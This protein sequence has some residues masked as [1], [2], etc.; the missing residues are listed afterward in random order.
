MLDKNNPESK[1]REYVESSFNIHVFNENI[2][3]RNIVFQVVKMQ[4]SC[5]VF[6]NDKED[7]QLLNLTLSLMSRFEKEPISTNLIGLSADNT[8]NNIAT[9]LTKK[10]KKAVYVSYNLEDSRTLTPAV[11]KRLY[12]EIRTNP[13]NF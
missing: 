5:M 9:K 12:D 8:S 1:V 7:P 3:E 10:L 11:E 4:E 6:I 13:N 2:F